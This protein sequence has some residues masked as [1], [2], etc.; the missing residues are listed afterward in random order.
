M[1]TIHSTTVCGLSFRL[2]PHSRI[3]AP[4]CRA[5][6]IAAFDN[7]HPAISK[8]LGQRRGSLIIAGQLG[9]VI[10]S[11]QE[12]RHRHGMNRFHDLIRFGSQEGH[13]RTVLGGAPDPGKCEYRG[14]SPSEPHPS[15]RALLAFPLAECRDRNQ[16]AALRRVSKSNQ[17]L[18]KR[19]SVMGLNVP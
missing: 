2:V 10:G 7:F 6:L 5:C 12:H 15:L 17:V 18:P 3:L 9:V 16:T 19:Y 13:A 14:V 11:V 8:R 4:L 1:P